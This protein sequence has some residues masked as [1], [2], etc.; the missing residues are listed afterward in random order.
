[1]D[2]V[3]ALWP[4]LTLESRKMLIELMLQQE[5]G[6][7]K[8]FI[9]AVDEINSEIK[10]RAREGRAEQYLSNIDDHLKAPIALIEDELKRLIDDGLVISVKAGSHQSKQTTLSIVNKAKIDWKPIEKSIF[11]INES[12][13]E[14]MK[15]RTIKGLN[16]SDRIWEKSIKTRNTIGDIVRGAIAEGEHPYKVTEMLDSYVKKGANTFAVN[17]PNMMERLGNLPMDLSYESLRLARTE[18]AAAYGK[19]TVESAKLNPGVIGI[20]WQVSNAGVTCDVCKGY[21]NHDSGLGKGVFRLDEL[22]EY[23]AHPNCLCTLIEVTENLDDLVDKL[24]EWNKNPL[25]QPDVE[26]WYQNVYQKGVA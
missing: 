10:K 5:Q 1:M 18:M 12:A 7:R 11:R 17:Y 19:A 3:E 14:T 2:A 20:Q 24:I 23:P 22:P 21:A 15:Q 6:I 16:L 9:N 4:K 13:I 26:K 8:V 25:S